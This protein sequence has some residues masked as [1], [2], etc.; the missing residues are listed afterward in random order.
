[1]NR[2]VKLPLFWPTNPRA[3]F[4]SVVGSF[5]LRNIVDK[6]SRFFN[7][8]L[9]AEMLRLCPRCQDNND[10]FNYLYLN[11]LQR[12]LRAI[13]TKA[14]RQDRQAKKGS[15]AGLGKR[16]TIHGRWAGSRY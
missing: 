15:G 11:K 9:L 4:A 13:L 12:E 10:L 8:L 14:D 2:V 6:E 1:M 3:W 16:V 5:R 7:C